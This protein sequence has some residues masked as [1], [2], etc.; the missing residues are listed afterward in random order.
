MGLKKDELNAGVQKNTFNFT[1]YNAKSYHG[2][3]FGTIKRQ[4]AWL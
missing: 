3:L 2:T 1:F 4:R